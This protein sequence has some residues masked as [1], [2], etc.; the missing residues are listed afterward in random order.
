MSRVKFTLELQSGNS[1]I[2][3][4]LSRKTEDNN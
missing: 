1:E 2:K 4:A 3:I